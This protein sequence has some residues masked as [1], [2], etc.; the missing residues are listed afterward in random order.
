MHVPIR[1]DYGVRALLDLAQHV[2]G[3]PV[4]AADIARRQGIPEPFLARLLLTLSHGGF[5]RSHTGPQ[6]GHSLALAPSEISLGMVMAALGGVETIVGC[7]DHPEQ[8]VHVPACA[9]REVWRTV[10][11][12]MQR[13]LDSTTIA[14]LVA[15]TPVAA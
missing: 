13:V 1:V 6:G 14:D 15:R 7:L 4:R 11:E 5:V 2:D 10:E 12:A 3:A 9:Q 8:C